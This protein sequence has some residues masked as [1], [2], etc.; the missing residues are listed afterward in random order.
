MSLLAFN[1]T[2]LEIIILQFGA[3]V[4]GITIYFFWAS[5]KALSATLK[6]SRIKLAIA[7]K[8]T[9]FERLGTYLIT[10]E[11]LQER[12]SKLKTKPAEIIAKKLQPVQVSKNV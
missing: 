4:L 5:N 7:P 2:L 9:I 12:V 11:D 3:I 10:I 1:L 8:R 6:E